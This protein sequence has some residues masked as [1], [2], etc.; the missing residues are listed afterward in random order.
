MPVT[1]WCHPGGI[2]SETRDGSVAAQAGDA[3]VLDRRAVC[4]IIHRYPA[5]VGS[6]G[7]L[8]VLG[9]VPEGTPLSC[10]TGLRARRY[11]GN[12]DIDALRGPLH[13]S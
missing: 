7:A 11:D 5:G 3:R 1:T 8:I 12:P 13:T 6:R 9:F 2:L 4:Y 10:T